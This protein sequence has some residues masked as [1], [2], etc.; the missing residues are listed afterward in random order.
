[1][2]I[3]GKCLDP[4]SG[5]E[6]D[7]RKLHTVELYNFSTIL[8]HILLNYDYQNKYDE[9]CGTCSGHERLANCLQ[10]FGQEYRR[11]RHFGRQRPRRKGNNEKN[12]KEFVSEVS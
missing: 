8:H 4:S 11:E 10:I 5:R 9:V 2:C 12:F 7:W 3:G 6:R 1:L